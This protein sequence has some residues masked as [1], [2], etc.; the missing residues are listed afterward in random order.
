M[1]KL[2]TPAILNSYRPK[3]DKSVSITFETD[4]KNGHQIMELHGLTGSYGALVFKPEEQLTTAEIK[5]ID[6]LDLEVSGKTKAQRL[7]NVLYKVW[8]TTASEY[9]FKDF[10]AERME[11]LID[12][13]KEEII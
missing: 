11:G 4:E 8:E 9:E 3:K 12:K 6:E 5:E 7:R 10:Y 13:A 1:N 2:I